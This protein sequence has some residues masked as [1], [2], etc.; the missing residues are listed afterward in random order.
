MKLRSLAILFLIAPTFLFAQAKSSID[1][2]GGVEY[3]YRT[4]GLEKD[5][6]LPSII[7]D[8]RDVE[9][10]NLNWRVGFNYARRLNQRFY[11]KSGLRLASVGYRL[12]T[13]GLRFWSMPDGM[14]GFIVTP[15]NPDLPSEIAWSTNRWF[16]EVPVMGRLVLTENGK[17]SPFVEA[18]VSP[19]FYLTTR[20]R[21]TTNLEDQVENTSDRED[22]RFNGLH[23]VGNLSFGL[24][25]DLSPAYQL[26]GQAIM[27]YHFTRTYDAPV[28]ENLYNYGLELGLRRLFN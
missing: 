11:L 15:P 10:A 6:D 3:S 22:E 12:P 18:G 19:S 25:Y 28:Q 17:I 8:V 21:V 5:S 20:N 4:V 27:R 13:E 23:F 26:F 2:V 9:V 16:L 1:F 24:N 14:G 7:V